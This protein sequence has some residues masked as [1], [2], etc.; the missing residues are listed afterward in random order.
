MMS[1]DAGVALKK[2]KTPTLI[3]WGDKD[4]FSRSEQDSLVSAIPNATLKVYKD[5]GHA[6]H[7]ERPEQFATDVQAFLDEGN[8]ERAVG[9]VDSKRRNDRR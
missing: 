7:W 9:Q 1:P 5:T 8:N 2:I 3:I 4:F 6:T